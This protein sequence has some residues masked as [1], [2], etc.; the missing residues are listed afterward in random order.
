MKEHLNIKE[1]L[2]TLTQTKTGSH[3]RSRRLDRTPIWPLS[4]QKKKR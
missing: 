4:F 1:R 2:F 3:S